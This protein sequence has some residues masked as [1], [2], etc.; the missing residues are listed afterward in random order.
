MIVTSK[1]ASA[2]SLLNSASLPLLLL[3][4]TH[5]LS[6]VDWVKDR[7]VFVVLIGSFRYVIIKNMVSESIIIESMI[8]F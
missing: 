1:S 8:G 6:G 4:S 3:A 2:N 7:E 5:L